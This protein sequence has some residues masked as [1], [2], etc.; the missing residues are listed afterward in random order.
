M[1]ET[2]AAAVREP[3]RTLLP[4]DHETQALY[5]LLNS[6]VVPRPIAWVSSLASDGTR[7]LAPHSYF[8][9]VASDPPTIGFTSIGDKDT[10]AN[11]RSTGEFVVHVADHALVERMNMTAARAPADVSEFGLAGVTPLDSSHVAPATVAEAPVSM[12]CELD[13]V[14]E[15]GNGR[16]VIGRVVA[17]HVA[18]RLWDERERVEPGRLDAVAR[19]GG[20]TYATTRDRFELRRPTYEELLARE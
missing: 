9:V 7:N 11:V 13:R 15:V 14:V 19:M 16:F 10:L 3:M 17:F 5:F 20:S 4:A 6:L 12:E 2:P 1:D 18:E 8:T